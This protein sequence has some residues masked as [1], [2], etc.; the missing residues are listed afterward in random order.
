MS[1]EDIWHILTILPWAIFL[2]YWIAGSL[3]TRANAQKE[4]FLSR[5]IILLMEFAGYL[6]VFA[7]F[8]IGVLRFH[9]IPRTI[10]SAILGVAST[11][12]GIGLAIWA[13]YHLAEYWSARITIKEGHQLIRTGPYRRL[14]H[15]IYTGLILATI[16]SALVIDHW[17]C[18]LG[19]LLV[20]VG[21]CFKAKREEAMLEKQFGEAFQE[22]RKHTGFL[23]PKF[24]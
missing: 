6:L 22:H 10:P 17:R 13:R 24:L 11:W 16:G 12:A 5:F 19:V 7:P 9:V 1:A 23:F 15:P 20:T 3:K 21:Y 8:N 18:V 14:R 4:P 2:T